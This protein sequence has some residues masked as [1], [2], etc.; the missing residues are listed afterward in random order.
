MTDNTG[1]IKLYRKL[2]EWEWIDDPYTL[3]LF[4]HLLLQANHEDQKW[5]GITIKRGEH[6]TSLSKLSKKTGISIRRIRTS[7]S[8]LKSTQ[9]VTQYRH[10]KYTHI[11][12]NN[13]DKYNEATQVATCKRHASDMQAT[14]NKN[15]KND[16]NIVPKGTKQNGSVKYGDFK[17][18]TIMETFEA[19]Y[20][21]KPIDR[22]ARNRC[23]N[24]ATGLIKFYR[25]T[26]NEDISSPPKFKEKVVKFFGWV[27]NQESLT[28][29]KSMD[30]IYRNFKNIW[31]TQAAAYLKGKHG[32]N[33]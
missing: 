7:L 20:G 12:V 27:K 6:I 30:I 16:K 1:W 25:E 15:D 8:R 29:A 13:Y 4:I 17:V 11:K 26:L 3:S 24:L 2:L 9:E 31:I 33:N 18:N 5:H 14:T 19:V 21:F 28:G 32:N 10:N 22:Y 23:H